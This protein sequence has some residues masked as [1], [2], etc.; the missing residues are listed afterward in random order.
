MNFLERIFDGLRREPECI[1]LQEAWANRIERATAGELLQL[2]ARARGFLRRQ[3]LHPGDRCVLLGP[4]SIRWAAMDLALMAEGL[5]RVPLYT[6]QAPGELVTMMHDCGAVLVLCGDE[7]AQASVQEHWRE[8][9]VCLWSEV[10]VE[11]TASLDAAASGRLAG[12][13]GTFVSNTVDADTPPVVRRAEDPVAIIYTSGTSGDA[14]GVVLTVGNLDHMLPCILQ[15]M[16]A[17]MRGQH[18]QERVFHYLPFCFAGS[19]MLLLSSLTRRSLLTLATDLDTLLDALR[20]ASPH[21][22]QNVP[23]LLERMRAGIE[24]K[25][26]KGVIGVLYTHARTA[27]RR[28]RD[29]RRSGVDGIW[30]A[31]ARR[32]LFARVRH[33]ISPNLEALICGSAPLAEDTQGF[34]EMLGIPVLQVYGLTETTAI[35][36]MDEPHGVRKP[37]RV[38]RAIPGITMQLG[39]NEEILVRGPHL[40][41]GYWNRPEETAACMQDGWFRT[42]DQGDVDGDGLWRI[43]GRVKNLIVLTSGHKLVPDPLEDALRLA[44][45]HAQQV[46]LIGNERKHLTAIITGDVTTSDIDAALATLNR[47]QPHYKQVRAVHVHREPFSTESG[48]LTANGKLKRQ[49]VLE[50]FGRE[51]D[52]LYATPAAARA[53]EPNAAAAHPAPT[54]HLSAP[55]HGPG[56]RASADSSGHSPH[57][58]GGQKSS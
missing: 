45:P 29:G 49:R 47:A 25:L 38:G 7:R 24:A 48:L 14:K 10:F 51:I 23:L 16:D 32:L 26:T 21:Y 9:P 37:G 54:G 57:G 34:F 15:R 11:A 28:E 3:R 30:L 4:N 53:S 35:C 43:V 1:V 27:W 46:V 52:A 8:A 12:S 33:K 22:F 20:V 6:R 17:L 42:G 31:L 44:V 40:F 41:A 58:H 55:R 50:R 5:V 36:T 18:G 56:D 2:V 39:D 13:N 19:W